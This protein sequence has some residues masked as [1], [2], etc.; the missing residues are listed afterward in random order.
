MGP[1]VLERTDHRTNDITVHFLL[2]DTEDE[3][4]LAGSTVHITRQCSNTDRQYASTLG[5]RQS[6]NRDRTERI[7][8]VTVTDRT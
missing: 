2:R 7:T 3:T 5:Q 4:R 1:E 8:S 6:G